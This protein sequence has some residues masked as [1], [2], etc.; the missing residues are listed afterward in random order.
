MRKFGGEPGEWCAG[1]AETDS[2]FQIQ[3]SRETPSN[4]PGLAYREAHTAYAAADAVEYLVSAFGLR[5]ASNQPEHHPAQ[6]GSKAEYHSAPQEQGR[7][8]YVHRQTPA[9]T[10]AAGSEHPTFRKLAA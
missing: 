8:V 7:I 6:Q 3:D 1:V 2:K 10:A 4:M 5:P 9:A